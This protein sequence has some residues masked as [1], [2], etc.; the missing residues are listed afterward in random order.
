MSSGDLL[1]GQNFKFWSKIFVFGFFDW[2]N[3]SLIG[4]I[5]LPGYDACEGTHEEDVY[6]WNDFFKITSFW[7]LIVRPDCKWVQ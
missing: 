5:K 6:A 2:E 3:K 4:P 7:Y 1:S